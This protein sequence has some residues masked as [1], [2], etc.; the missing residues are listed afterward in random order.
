MTRQQKVPKWHQRGLS[1]TLTAL[2]LAGTLAAAPVAYA[3]FENGGFETSATDTFPWTT[4]AY[5]RKAANSSQTGIENFP[6][7]KFTDLTLTADAR[8]ANYKIVT[9]SD[10]DT[11]PVSGPRWGTYALKLGGSGGRQASSVEQEAT[12]SVAD[13]DP[14]DGKIHVRFA[15]APVLNNPAHKKENQPFFFVEVN[16][17]TKGTQLFH[18]F[19]FSNQNGI[20]WQSASGGVQFTDWQGFDISPGNGLLDVGDKVELKIY[21]SNCSEGASDHDA[22]V[23]LDAVGA[24]M[25][26]LSVQTEGPTSATPN[27]DITYTYNYTNGS[28][29]YALDS[30]V[31]ITTPF[32]EDG[33]RLEFVEGDIPA[34]CSTPAVDHVPASRGQYITCDVGDLAANQGGNL[35]VTFTVP[36]DASTT[37][38]DNVINN[39]DYNIYAASVSPFLGPLWKTNIPALPVGSELV[40]LG[41]TINNDGKSSYE[42]GGVE[43]YTVTVTN[44][45]GTATDGTVTQT[46]TGMGNDCGVL[47]FT[48]AAC[49]S[50][51]AGVKITY[52]TTSPLNPGESISYQV[53]GPV[54]STPNVNTIA[55]VA[56]TDPSNIDSNMP[57]NTA[58]MNTPTGI[59]QENLTVNTGGGGA[60][61]VLSTEPTFKCGDAIIACTSTGVTNGVVDGQEIRFTPVANTGSIFIGWTGC[62]A[63]V[64]LMEGNLCIL[65]GTG[66]QGKTVTAN[67]IDAVVVTPKVDPAN[68]KGSI[69][70]GATQVEKGTT[71]PPVFTIT[72]ELNYYPKIVT[73]TDTTCVGT[74]IGPDAGAYT[75]TPASPVDDNCQFTVQFKLPKPHVSVVVTP[76]TGLNIPDDKVYGKVTCTS[77][78][79]IAAP[80]AQCDVPPPPGVTQWDTV[81]CTP[82]AMVNPLAVGNA[83]VCE[84]GYTVPDVA[85][86]QPGNPVEI[87]GKSSCSA[88]LDC[89]ETDVKQKS[90]NVPALPGNPGEPHVSIVVTPPSTPLI[91]GNTVSGKVICTS[92]GAVTAKDA[93]CNVLP[94]A[95]IPPADW[96]YSCAPSQTVGSL[97]V[98]STI[99]CDYAYKVPDE[100]VRIDG[101]SG[102]TTGAACSDEDGKVLVSRQPNT[103]HITTRVTPPT[104]PL[105][106]G[107][108]V[109]GKV[110]CT[111]DGEVDAP[112]AFCNVPKPPNVDGWNLVC[113][114]AASV[115]PLTKGSVI[116][117]D[118]SYKVPEQPVKVTGNG[119]CSAANCGSDDAK[120]LVPRGA[121]PAPVGVPV[122]NPFALL[123]LA[124]GM[125]G[126]GARYARKRNAV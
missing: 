74:M 48:G 66:A 12:M 97:S 114:P 125:L 80:N 38:P 103:P 52:E 113:N 17:V 64:G 121:I 106:P 69:S 36:N 53:I 8:A 93:F 5:N 105:I 101:K 11:A 29:V 100:P 39:G 86:G 59:S 95:G 24:F 50:E 120:I 75:Y 21:V 111:S 10:F 91:P 67:F 9:A 31:Q 55:K 44:H 108:T 15:L 73:G 41:V 63:P 78:G 94:P 32:T 76:P 123:L 2:A 40:D 60:G 42:V 47:V 112:N 16:N 20:P 87:T 98:G 96:G 27:S 57:N 119:G 4:A 54:G 65:N 79:E 7:T 18:T 117:C 34:N 88:A 45:G 51:G 124:L 126:V 85:P 35:D 70:P 102:C 58:G 107:N 28:G 84:Y 19:N 37:S 92:D 3:G 77:D 110:T 118:Y 82:A 89:G 68:N 6:P 71:T 83:I 30:K 46:L 1:A 23:Y 61:H 22:V 115:N 13:I 14:I 90:P 49:A 56:P 81:S 62:E 116:A 99:E 72:P 43:T 26:G 104:E 109:T 33:K 25:P 122:D